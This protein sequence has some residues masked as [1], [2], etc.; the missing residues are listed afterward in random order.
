MIKE[1]MFDLNGTLY[2]IVYFLDINGDETDDYEKAC[3]LLLQKPEDKRP[4]GVQQKYL[5][6]KIPEG[7]LK[8][9]SP[10]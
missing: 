8:V 10:Q 4:E 7:S 2:R 5:G 9:V 6:Y 1:R 3:T